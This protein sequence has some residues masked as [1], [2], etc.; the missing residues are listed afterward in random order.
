M[1]CFR[2][3]SR[4][5][6]PHHDHLQRS[7][8]GRHRPQIHRLL[9]VTAALVAVTSTS[10]LMGQQQR[11]DQP[12]EQAPWR[13]LAEGQRPEDARLGDPKTL[14]G[15][16]P[17][18]V[19]ESVEAWQARRDELQRRV[20][21]AT[22]LWPMPERTPMQPVIHGKIDRDGFS[23][24]RV[25]F[26]SLPGH[27]VT[28]LLFRPAEASDTP[29]AGVLCPHGH[30]GRMQ[31]FSDADLAKQIE[32]GAEKY[33]N[34][35]RYPKLARCAQLARMG[36]VSFIFDMLGYAD[37]IQVG[38]ETSHRHRN[39]RPEERESGPW[40]FF[41]APAELRLQSIMGL[42]TWNSIRALDFLASLPDVDPERL[43][44]TGGSGGG[45]QSILLGA[46]DDRLQASF[47][48]GMVSTSM[49]GGCYCENCCLLRID[50]GNV[51]LA[52]MFAPR[53][54]SMTAANDWTRDMM[55]DGFPELRKLYA[56]LGVEDSV[57]CYPMLH[58]PHNY[59]YVSRSKMYAWMNRHLRLGLPEPIVE[60]DY[61]PL[62]EAE[63]AIWNEEHPAPT[64]TGVEHERKV[65]RW[66][67]EQSTNWLAGLFPSSREK[68]AEYHR[69]V[70]AAW[71]VLFDQPLPEPDALSVETVREANQD[72]VIILSRLVIDARRGAQIPILVLKRETAGTPVAN[73]SSGRVVIWSTQ[74]GKESA[75]TPAGDL[76]PEVL[77]LV[78]AGGEVV[79]PDLF[80]QG[81]LEVE[82]AT[83]DQQRLV[84]DDREYSAFTF[85]YNRTLVAERVA[86]LLSVVASSLGT[87]ERHV[88][89]VGGQRT[90]PWVLPTAMIAGH[91]LTRVAVDTAGFRFADVPHFSH[92]DFVPGAV[93]YGDLPAL[94][95]LRAPYSLR[96]VGEQGRQP[97]VAAAAYA[98]L[99]AAEEFSSVDAEILS[100]ESI[101]WLLQ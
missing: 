63:A 51:E 26:E 14:N 50:T 13:V 73:A 71:R 95:A 30:G 60:L 75:F 56:M 34:S 24:E 94:M 54:Q 61:Q 62:S 59:N 36:C 6:D 20:L 33:E 45:T 77:R 86:D 15:H 28:G 64:E 41:S 43:A 39:P 83:E 80:G 79:I 3:G 27:F 42:Q 19:P 9:I 18:Q 78:E 66:F 58:F 101:R 46:I 23:V 70:G 11:G 53:P 52:A 32:M 57:D 22:G 99:E 93:K 37:S 90:A 74:N 68:I 47:P 21:V 97:E 100:P 87:D 40:C 89:L 81:E 4:A 92:P 88:T 44:V 31:R 29:R 67:D 1:S 38:Y 16:F 98:S 72:G 8:N 17:F 35:G 7:S 96:I 85:G 55:N 76:S 82:G 48:N 10:E 49:Q 2:I 12:S 65:L 5:S 91:R 69:W 25:Y 84:N